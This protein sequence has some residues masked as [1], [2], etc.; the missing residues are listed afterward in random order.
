H[1]PNDVARLETK[2]KNGVI[3]Y[4]QKIIEEK[5]KESPDRE[6]ITQYRENVF[7]FMKGRD[8]LISILEK[9]YPEYYSFKYNTKTVSVS[10]IVN[11]IG[12]NSNYIN[13]VIGDT[14]I[15][16]FVANKK[17]SELIT[18]K[19][20]S[21][22]FR[23]AD[24]FRKLIIAPSTG[25]ITSNDLNKYLMAGTH[26]YSIIFEPIRKYLISDRLVVS[27]DNILSYLPFDA[28]PSEIDPTNDV[29]FKKIHYLMIDYKISYIYSATFL[30]ESMEKNRSFSNKLLA[31]SPSYADSVYINSKLKSMRYLYS[32]LKDIPFARVEAKFAVDLIGG[33]L[34]ANDK[35]LE[36]VFK[37]EVGKYDIIHLAM[38]SIINEENPMQS[39]MIFYTKN[40]S[41][42][43]GALNTYEIC[44]LPLKAKMIVLSSCNTGVGLHQSGEGILNLARGFM[45]S[46][47]QSIVMSLWD[48]EDRSG[49]DVIKRFYNN[50]KRGDSKSDAL[51]NARLT[52]LKN[53]DMLRSHPYFWSTMVVYGNDTPLYYST[54]IFLIVEIIVCFAIISLLWHFY[55]SR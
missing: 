6:I 27:P 47:S 55:W 24:D 18:T 10:E 36:S 14:V 28:I 21:S 8:S 54:Y 31:F 22:F 20:D 17:F 19:I 41:I 3:Y 49:S 9:E 30:A 1:V 16:I 15:Y 39:K 4:N 33:R 38:H 12:R 53:A 5:V 32:D 42:D 50:L 43:D 35:A 48:I 45:Y 46:G 29:F 37:N 7:K 40:D 13:Y 34:F 23:E 11:V 52:Y 26:L 2:F 25:V 44:T 51:R